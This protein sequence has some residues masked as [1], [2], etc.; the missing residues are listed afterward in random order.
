[1]VRSIVLATRNPGKLKEIRQVL[2]PLGVE[3]T[4]LEA[5]Q[6]VEEPPEH[7]STFAENARAKATAYARATGRWCLA[8][9]SGLLV[10]ALDG[11]PGVLSAR[12]AAERRPP[13]ASR[14]QIDTA[15]NTKLLGELKKIPD[16]KRTA[17]FICH[18]A[19]SDGEK[20]LLETS[21][22]V[23]G[24]IAHHPRGT[25]GF[26]YDPLFIADET[27]CTTAELPPERKNEISHR[28]KAVRSFA[29]LLK[30]F[31]QTRTAPQ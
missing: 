15:N 16:D 10:D 13:S 7:G 4:G 3:V 23:E 24:R 20:I 25:N 19:L 6:D 22:T 12:Y 2:A 14:Q 8:D 18:L 21:G 27:G 30:S 9:D 31:L 28:G 26:G 29:D 1:M 5:F 11:A 17:R